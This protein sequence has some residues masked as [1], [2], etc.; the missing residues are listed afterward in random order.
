MAGVSDGQVG[1]WDDFGTQI[2]AWKCAV[3]TERR[4]AVTE[5][6][7]GKQISGAQA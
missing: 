1:I 2:R 4:G 5:S 6:G 7:A 3:S